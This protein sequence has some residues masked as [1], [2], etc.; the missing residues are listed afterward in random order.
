MFSMKVS[1]FCLLI[2]V[3]ASPILG[4]SIDPATG[5]QLLDQ[6]LPQQ[7][8]AMRQRNRDEFQHGAT[9]AEMTQWLTVHK[10]GE[11]PN[12][13]SSMG[14]F[15]NYLDVSYPGD[16]RQLVLLYWC[17]ESG[18]I[19]W[20]VVGR[21][22][23]GPFTLVQDGE[24]WYEMTP[25]DTIEPWYS[26][27][28]NDGTPE[29][30]LSS[31]ERNAMTT[32]FVFKWQ[33]GQLVRI[34]PKA[35]PDDNFGPA[36]LY[37]ISAAPDIL[38]SVLEQSINGSGIVLE[39]LDGDGKA[40]IIVGPDKEAVI[41]KDATGRMIDRTWKAV[42]PTRIYHLV[43]GAYVFWKEAPADDPYPIAV[44]SFAVLHPGTL[45][46]SELSS[47]GNGDLQV[48]VS[49]PA[50]AATVDDIDTSSFTYNGSALL[51]KKRW[52]NQKQPDTTSANW[53]WE[54]CPVKQTAAKGQGEWNPSPE[55]P[56]L[57]SPDGKT[58]YHFVAPYLEFR[59]ARSAVFPY[60]L[61]QAQAAFAKEPSRQNYFIEIPISGKMK[62][63][64]LAAVSAL[65]CIKNTGNPAK[66]AL[67][68]A[69]QTATVPP[70]VSKGG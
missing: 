60:L 22:G 15:W 39:D 54:N 25:Y 55:D 26:D 32:L 44:P 45:A 30:L 59:L 29:L 46:F 68:P 40:E 69:P 63:G 21:T 38:S 51:F 67:Q 10:Q 8:V 70:A 4:A 7:V 13:V 47:P 43:N 17:E 53:E 3:T 64:K 61:Q 18:E 9:L 56:F 19:W 49:H 41:K 52:A 14:P 33:G 24:G 42:T 23:G 1:S 65:V 66:A 37:Y 50:G 48:F 20:R 5:A 31:G 28:D 62:N 16:P 57:P 36:L 2:A 6:F 34:S 27:L 11:V 12:R 35:R 58:E